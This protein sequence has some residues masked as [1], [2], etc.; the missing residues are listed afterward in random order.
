MQTGLHAI[1]WGLQRT[2]LVRGI[3]VLGAVFAYLTWVI[4][5]VVGQAAASWGS[6]RKSP[7]GTPIAATRR[8]S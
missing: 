4:V 7:K 3:L 5:I 6:C 1:G 2:G 8:P